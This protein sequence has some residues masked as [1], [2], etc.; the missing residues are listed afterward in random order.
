ML[1]GWAL[2]GRET[3][4]FCMRFLLHSLHGREL[5]IPQYKLSVK[6]YADIWHA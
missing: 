5:M 1:Y 6:E 3:F 2:E 4:G